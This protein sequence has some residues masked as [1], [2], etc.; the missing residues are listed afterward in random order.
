MFTEK[1]N[2][3]SNLVKYYLTSNHVYNDVYLYEDI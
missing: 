1:K 2:G 3:V